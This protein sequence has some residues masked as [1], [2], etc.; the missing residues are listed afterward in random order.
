[1]I[2]YKDFRWDSPIGVMKSDFYHFKDH[3]IQAI[4]PESLDYAMG[5]DP[6]RKFAVCTIRGKEVNCSYGT[7]DNASPE[8]HA[9]WAAEYMRNHFYWCVDWPVTIEGAAYNKPYGQVGLAYIRMGFYL[10]MVRITRVNITPPATVR[11]VAFGSG[12]VKAKDLWPKIND[13]AAA[14]VGCALHA[15]GVT[16]DVPEDFE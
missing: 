1:M 6:G 9:K 14:A 7:F 11:K 15:A 2:S 13:N 5:I 16:I 3:F 4:L 12:K 10:P 8:I